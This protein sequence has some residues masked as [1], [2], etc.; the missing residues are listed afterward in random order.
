MTAVASTVDD[1]WSEVVG[2]DD[3]VAQL[4]AAAH[5]PVHAYLL[6]G[7][8]GSGKRAAARAFA[9]ELLLGG[10][11]DREAGDATERTARLVAHEDH[12]ALFV[13]ERTGA[14]LREEEISEVVRSAAMSPPE[15]TVQVFVLVDFHLVGNQA[16]RVL[17]SI[18]EP[19]PGTVFVVL[20]EEV[21]PELVTIASRCVTVEFRAVAEPVLLERLRTEGVDEETARASVASAGGSLRRA[22]LLATDPGVL[23]RREAW[24]RAPERLD[25]TG[26]TAAGLV[27]ELFA[28]IDDVLAPLVA[29]Q[30]AETADL[31]ALEEELGER[32]AGDRKLLEARHNREQRR[33]RTD[34]LR[35]GLAALLSRYRDEASAGGRAED[36]VEASER[37]Q[38]LTDALVFNP[39]EQLQLLD[40]FLHLPRPG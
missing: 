20:A 4:R 23:A 37:V 26:A 33:V 15:G 24:Y 31:D 38:E 6:V 7:P 40:L 12:P 8:E 16:P 34:E 14:S 5:H 18:E 21:T 32:R 17:K 3:A 39:R 19:H 1:L 13:V 29:Q 25:G 28:S 2:Q 27:D 22:R 35:A 30:E 9:A 11:D 36:F 10:T